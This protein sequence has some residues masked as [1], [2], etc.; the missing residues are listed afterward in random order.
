[1]ELR[2]DQVFVSE[3]YIVKKM[4]VNPSECF[5]CD[6]GKSSWQLFGSG[7]RILIRF[8]FFVD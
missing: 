4:L 6:R 8:V 1:M 5:I 2:G 7:V 3:L